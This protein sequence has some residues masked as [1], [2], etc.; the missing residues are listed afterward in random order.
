MVGEHDGRWQRQARAGGTQLQF[1]WNRIYND[2]AFLLTLV[3][4]HFALPRLP[5]KLEDKFCGDARHQ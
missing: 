4:L 1:L 5:K 3:F 2:V